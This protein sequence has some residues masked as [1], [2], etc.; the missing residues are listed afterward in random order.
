MKKGFNP[1][2]A[3]DGI[4]LDFLRKEFPNL[5][6]IELPSYNIKYPKNGTWLK[7]K[8]LFQ[9][10]PIRKAIKLERKLV[11]SL[12]VSEKLTGI[13]S[14]NRMGVR[15]D[16]IPS[17]YITHQINVYSGCTTFLT[18]KIHQYYI[19]QF[20]ECWVPDVEGANGLSGML[21]GKKLKIPKKHLGIL[22]RFQKRNFQIK[23]D[24]LVLLSG[25]EP[26]RTQLEK[27]LASELKK[28]K[29]SVLFVRGV[30]SEKQEKSIKKHITYV[31]FLLSGALE[32]AINES[33]LVLCR[34]GYS[35]ILDLAKLNKSAFF[36]P[37]KGQNEQ[38][39][40]AKH[41]EKLKIAPFS[42]EEKFKIEMLDQ[43]KGYCGFSNMSKV[44][45]NE[46][47][48]DVFKERHIY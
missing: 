17:I 47:L 30:I 18:S 42:S 37:T 48:F 24:I 44:D 26:L 15:S 22:S 25:T 43:V 3:S 40:L 28:Y 13:I 29:G 8:L 12:V 6:F 31:N 10:F 35:T 9:S 19:H 20:D 5:K 4:A 41:L 46:F 36:I 16:K 38:E 34:S 14:D 21:S 39:Y 7:W 23:Y 11:E 2:I 32:I 33:K 45:F 1:I 27:K